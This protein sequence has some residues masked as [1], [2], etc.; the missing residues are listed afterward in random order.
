MCWI[1]VVKDHA[2]WFILP[3]KQA[4]LV[5]YKLQEMCGVIGYPKIMH[6]DNG[7]DFKAKIVLELLCNF[8]P[9]ILS[10]YRQPACS[11]DRGSVEN[12][13]KFVGAILSERKM[14]GENPNWTEVLGSV[15]AAINS[16]HGRCKDEVSSFKAVYVQV[17]HHELSCSNEEARQCWTVPQQLKVTNDPDFEAYVKDHFHLDDDGNDDDND[18][19]V[20][21]EPD[22]SA[23]FPM[24]P[25]HLARRK[26]CWIV[27]RRSRQS[28]P[29]MEL[30]KHLKLIH[31]LK[32]C[33][34]YL[35]WN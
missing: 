2:T 17:L 10:V 28:S 23:T 21:E 25:C 20:V 18:D 5:A 19:N 22:N 33:P 8:N 13:N 6:S 32:R 34:C 29:P 26:R 15:A 30:R 3:R 14:I 27:R 31:S 16:Q 35:Q 1:L 11:Q 7:K 4:D 24:D 12:M 9:N